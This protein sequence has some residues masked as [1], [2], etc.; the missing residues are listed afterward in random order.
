MIGLVVVE[1]APLLLGREVVAAEVEGEDEIGL[2]DDLAR[3]EQVVGIVQQQRV[4]V[5]SRVA[6]KSQRR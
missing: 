2:L 1:V 4:L 3:V 6:A 5:R